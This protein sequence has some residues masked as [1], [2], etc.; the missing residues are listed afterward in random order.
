MQYLAL[1]IEQKGAGMDAKE[2]EK[3]KPKIREAILWCMKDKKSPVASKKDIRDY[4]SE[5]GFELEESF[6]EHLLRANG[7]DYYEENDFIGFREFSPTL[8]NEYMKVSRKKEAEK[9]PY[10]ISGNQKD[11]SDNKSKIQI[12]R[13]KEDKKIS[14]ENNN[15]DIENFAHFTGYLSGVLDDLSAKAD[16]EK[17][18]TENGILKSYIKE[19]FKVIFLDKEKYFTITD[20]GKYLCFNTGLLT[21]FCSDIYAIF[22]KNISDKK[23][24]YYKEWYFKEWATS[25]KAE[26]IF[27]HLPLP[28]YHNFLQSKEDVIFN[29][30]YEITYNVEHILEE[31]KDRFPESFRDID[32]FSKVSQ[33]SGTLDLTKRKISRDHRIAVPQY[34]NNELGFFLPMY[35]PNEE[36][37]IALAVAKKNNK[38]HV[39]TCLTL[40][41]AYKNARV[42]GKVESSWLKL[43]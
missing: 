18:G 4:Y 13:K 43:D 19:Y 30:N 17:W 8:Q 22:S 10:S 5:K 36:K 40:D 39:N 3:K 27:A 41:M 34:Y 33:L 23:N 15:K 21:P 31:N 24:K 20:D 32:E 29:S 1:F 6:F 16:K 25:S 7:K 2:S 11:K 38:Y 42:V 14:L 26:K 9:I 35:F 28:P 37:P 12:V